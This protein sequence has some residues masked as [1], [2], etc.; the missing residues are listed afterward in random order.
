MS[1][2]LYIDHYLGY[3][4]FVYLRGINLSCRLLIARPVAILIY[5][6]PIKDSIKL[7]PN[8]K[9]LF[10]QSAYDV[11][12]IALFVYLSGYCPVVY[13]CISLLYL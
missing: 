6:L 5:G 1:L 10:I 3:V 12:L 13:M 9:S 11:N 2:L 8:C 7:F 4:A